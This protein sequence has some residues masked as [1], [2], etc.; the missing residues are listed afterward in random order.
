MWKSKQI[1]LRCDCRCAMFV[2]DK[3]VYSDGDTNY[4]I[5]IQDSRYDHHY[6][7]VWGRIKRACKILFGKPLYYSDVYIDEP[8]IFN[9]FLAEMNKLAE[10]TLEIE[11]PA[12]MS[13][14]KRNV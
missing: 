10:W 5:L 13:T 12:E 6:N 9:D 4:N 11:K 8:Q 2:V 3:T 14:E 7:T 1:T